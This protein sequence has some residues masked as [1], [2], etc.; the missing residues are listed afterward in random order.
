MAW[1]QWSVSGRCWVV[2]EHFE[3]DEAE[4]IAYS[5]GLHDSGAKDLMKIAAEV[6]EANKGLDD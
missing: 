4:N 2:A 5:L 6:R 1:K 3:A